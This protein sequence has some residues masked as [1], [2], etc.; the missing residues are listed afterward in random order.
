MRLVKLEI[1][2]CCLAVSMGCGTSESRPGGAPIPAGGAAPPTPPAESWI[3]SGS[4]AVQ[5]DGK[6]ADQSDKI[7]VSPGAACSVRGKL[8][9]SADAPGA[10]VVIARIVHYAAGKPMIMS[11]SVVQTEAPQSGKVDFE[12]E[13]KAPPKTGSFKLEVIDGLKK[14]HVVCES[15]LVVRAP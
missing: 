5:I 12:F 6:P 10:P 9:L 8:S 13:L 2:F 1:L 11:S 4:M 14:S 7:S 15:E 3:A